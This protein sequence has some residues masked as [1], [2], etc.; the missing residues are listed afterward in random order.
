M[1][2]HKRSLETYVL[3]IVWKR[4]ELQQACSKAF[5]SPLL[6]TTQPQLM[7]SENLYLKLI[8]AVNSSPSPFSYESIICNL[9]TPAACFRI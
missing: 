4:Q 8:F 7:N 9:L 1:T 6:T 2:A 3:Y 5:F